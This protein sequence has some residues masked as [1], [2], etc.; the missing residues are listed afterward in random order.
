MIP[1]QPSSGR[2]T[3][4]GA[5]PAQLPIDVLKQAQD[6]IINWNGTGMGILEV[7]HRSREFG[8]L[9]KEAELRLRR[10]VEIP[11]DYAVLFMPGGGTL[12]F[13]AVVMNLL[14][15][16]SSGS[17][18]YLIS[19]NWS[20]K[21]AEE[22][23]KLLSNYPEILVNS[24][25]VL[26]EGMIT[27]PS[28]WN[29]SPQPRYIYY[30][31]NETIDGI[32]FPTSTWVADQLQERG[33]NAPIIADLSS[34]FL[35]R[36]INV[37]KFG[38]VYA[39]AQK[40]FGPA[41][42]TVVIVRRSLLAIRPGLPLPT[43]LDYR[44]FEKTQSLHNTPPC[45]AIYMCNLV[46]AWLERQFGDLQAIDKYSLSKSGLINRCIDASQGLYK[47]PVSPTARSRMNIVMRIKNGDIS[48]EEKFS[49]EAEQA[50]L[51]QLKGHRSVGGIRISLYNA[52]T[53]EDTAKV[54]QFMEYFQQKH[55]K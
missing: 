54:V 48:L 4:F 39:T 24:V 23:T 10:L 14:D 51:F 28:T 26:S 33:I 13:S 35:S 27:D 37:S 5:G 49:K 22:A 47:C 29:I 43:M 7:S 11:D 2:V 31:D 15:T 41:G 32:E 40:N 25:N 19:G 38:L 50:G 44:V 6:D 46:F 42:V 45:F 8:G 21:A 12:Q 20:S 9:M 52:V 18:D 36:P 3:N 30:C 53:M 16:K 34:N 55:S 17:I 1:I